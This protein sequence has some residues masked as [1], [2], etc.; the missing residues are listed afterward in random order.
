MSITKIIVVNIDRG[1]P[2]ES[3]VTVPGQSHISKGINELIAEQS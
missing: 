3:I 2:S 1:T